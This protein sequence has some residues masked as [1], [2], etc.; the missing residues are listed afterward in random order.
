MKPVA[1]GANDVNGVWRNE[2]VDALDA[3]SNLHPEIALRCP[4]LMRTPAAPHVAAQLDGVKIEMTHILA[5]YQKLRALADVVVVEGVGGFRVP[6]NDAHDTADLAKAL[7]LPIVLVVGLR[8]GCINQALLTYEAIVARGLPVLGWVA[9]GAQETMAYE[10]NTIEALQHRLST[11]LIGHIPRLSCADAHLAS[12][13]L[14][15]PL[16]TR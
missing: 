12:N 6:L 3:A 4:Y 14:K 9:N 13:Y 16:E 1:A 11:P 8:L 5:Q 15:W 7:N 10:K 2:D